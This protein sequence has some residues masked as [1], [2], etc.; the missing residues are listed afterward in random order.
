MGTQF[1]GKTLVADP[2][3]TFFRISALTLTVLLI[4]TA[5]AGW[6][7][8]SSQKVTETSVHN[9]SEFYLQ[10]LST[11]TGD[12][13]QSNLDY[14]AKN[15]QNAIQTIRPQDLADDSSLQD[16]LQDAADIFGFDFYA[17]FDKE[18][19]VYAADGTFSEA[20]NLDFFSGINFCQ[21]VN[22]IS[23]TRPP[24]S[25]VMITTPVQGLTF[26]GKPLSGGMIGINASAVLAKLSLKNDANQIFSNIILRDGSYGK[27]GSQPFKK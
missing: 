14:L 17:L 12:H 25:M 13:L 20:F 23:Q 24:Q 27:H 18:G 9:V 26:K 2:K 10:E 3:K 16:C 11:Q 15:L 1:H 8:D 22:S 21:P 6:F 5:S 7:M 19:T 4:L